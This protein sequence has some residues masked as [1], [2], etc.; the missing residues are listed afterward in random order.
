MS[1]LPILSKLVD[2]VAR[3]CLRDVAE[4]RHAE[5][6]LKLGL[7]V[8]ALNSLGAKQPEEVALLGFGHL[9][10]TVG[11]VARRLRPRGS[12]RCGWSDCRAIAVGRLA[13]DQE[14][15]EWLA[16]RMSDREVPRVFAVGVHRDSPFT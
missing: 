12:A 5:V 15:H 7:C 6:L 2:V 13:L 16:I 10:L 8:L 3:R 11:A 14:R 9:R 4:I 1:V